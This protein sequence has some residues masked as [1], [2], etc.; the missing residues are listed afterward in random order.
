MLSMTPFQCDN[1][2]VST[3]CG[4]IAIYENN[5][6]NV[7][8]TQ[9]TIMF[10]FVSTY[11]HLRGICVNV[12]MAQHMRTPDIN[13]YIYILIW[14]NEHKMKKIKRDHQQPHMKFIN[15]WTFSVTINA[16]YEGYNTM[17][18]YCM[19]SVVLGYN[20]SR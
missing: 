19:L 8:S 15:Q 12:T 13:K 14:S 11:I 10:L 9:T 6:A 16:Q 18:M 1:V 5:E 2:A 7:D 20:L 4:L 17:Q 3:R